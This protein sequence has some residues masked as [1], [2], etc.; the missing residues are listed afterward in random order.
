MSNTFLMNAEIRNEMGRTASRSSRNNGK[1]PAI[2]YGEKKDP[3]SINVE[4]KEYQKL[5]SQKGV[6]SRLIDLTIDGK[7]NIVLTKDIQFHPVSDNPLHI[8]FLRIGEGSSVTVSIPVNFKNEELSP[9]L[10]SGGVLNVV[11]YDLELICPASSIPSTIEIEL[12][13]L[14]IGD[15]IHISS[16]KLPDGVKPT[17]TDRDFTIATIAAPTIQEIE[18]EVS[19]EKPEEDDAEEA[20]EE[21]TQENES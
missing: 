6:F 10:K 3:I 20:P 13:D 19:E 9:G 5:L 7:S 17:I 16:I 8:D 4:T 2:V 11:R 18:T 12:N 15:S 1:I 21:K 14:N